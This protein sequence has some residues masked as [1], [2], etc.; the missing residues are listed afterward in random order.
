MWLLGPRLL[1]LCPLMWAGDVVF[2]SKTY[3]RMLENLP[4]KVPVQQ[5]NSNNSSSNGSSPGLA[6][7]GKPI[8]D[9][10]YN[11]NVPA[12]EQTTTMM[13][14]RALYVLVAVTALVVVYFVVRTIRI[15]K[16]HRK[17]RKYGVL[18][19]NLENMEMKPLDQEDDDEDDT[20]FDVHQSRR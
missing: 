4:N 6:A 13:I 9:G 8:K 1:W 7:G 19:T 20:L 16:I 11:S 12:D 18:S 15:R 17:N 2:N 3:G 5:V 10:E 14:Q